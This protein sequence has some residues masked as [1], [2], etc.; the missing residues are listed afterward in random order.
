MRGVDLTACDPIQEKIKE[1]EN[2]ALY[3]AFRYD[4]DCLIQVLLAIEHVDPW[5]SSRRSR[6]NEVIDELKKPH[7]DL[8]HTEVVLEHIIRKG[9]PDR[10]V[11]IHDDKVISKR[12]IEL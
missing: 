3:D 1:G 8:T 9:D 2:V 6:E 10:S 4:L 5:Q 7:P 11:S 12:L